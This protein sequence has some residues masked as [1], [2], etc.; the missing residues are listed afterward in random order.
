MA[1][2]G[3]LWFS[4]NTSTHLTLFNFPPT[5]S[6]TYKMLCQWKKYQIYS[7]N[8]WE[9]GKEKLS[10]TENTTKGI[11][12]NIYISIHYFYPCVYTFQGISHYNV[13]PLL[14]WTSF[15][16]S[17][18]LLTS[19]YYQQR[20]NNTKYKTIS[21]LGLSLIK[22]QSLINSNMQTIRIQ[23]NIHHCYISYVK[24]KK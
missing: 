1:A 4:F 13:P 17:S 7:Y 24:K 22:K 23:L 16:L 12:I 20:S 14:G 19:H 2:Y 5:I 3:K 11:A 15:S 21:N 10:V 8:N 18:K 6:M 9:Y